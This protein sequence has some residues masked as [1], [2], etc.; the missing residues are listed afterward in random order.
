MTVGRQKLIRNVCWWSILVF[1]VVMA[2]YA[3]AIIKGLKEGVLVTNRGVDVGNI[4]EGTPITH[5]FY[6]WNTSLHSQT[7][8][9]V[10]PSCH[11]SVAKVSHYKISPFS[12]A[13]IT[14]NID[15][16]GFPRGA[17]ARGVMI[18]MINGQRITDADITFTI[19]RA[20]KAK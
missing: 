12:Y 9:R 20:K 14:L 4:I 8:S 2:L 16:K 13:T 19:D 11:C 7:I 5:K 3:P 6:L 1:C 18:D 15:T 17:G 10:I